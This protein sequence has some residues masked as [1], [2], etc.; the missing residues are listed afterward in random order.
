MNGCAG[1]AHVV[2]KGPHR[3]V[4]RVELPDLCFY[5][6]RNLMTDRW[7][8]IRQLV[9]P[10]KARMEYE[11]ARGVAERGLPTYLP[12]ALGEQRT[13]F[14]PGESILITR[15]LE[16]TQELH[17]FAV[18]CLARLPAARQARLRQC[19][20]LELGRLVARMHDAGI[21]HNDLHP[22]NILVRWGEDDNL[23]LFLVD[24]S[25]VRL[26][27]PLSW[28]QSRQNLVI[29][30]RWFVLRAAAA[31]ATAF[32][33]RIAAIDNRA[34]VAPRCVRAKAWTS[35]TK[36]KRTRSRPT[37]VSGGA[38]IA[39]ASKTIATTAASKL[40]ACA[41]TRSWIWTR[42]CWRCC[43]PTRTRLLANPACASLKDSPSSTVI[44]WDVVSDGQPRT[45]IYKRFLVSSWFHP[46]TTLLRRTPALRSWIQGQGFRERGL[47]TARPLAV[48]HRCRRGLYREGYLLAEKI[49][50]AQDLREFLANLKRRAPECKMAVLRRQIAQVATVLRE[51]HRR[52]LSHRDLKAANV[53]VSRDS[54]TFYSPFSDMAWTTGTPS[55]LPIF[56]TSVWLID[57]VGVRRY[58]WLARARMV[59]NLTRLNASFQQRDTLTRTDRLRFLRTYLRWS[60][61][62]KGDWKSWW[63]AIERATQ[64]KISRNQKRGRP[65]E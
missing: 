4:Y 43:R 35:P 23:D 21:C 37:C 6:K 59:Q 49:E 57:L 28:K 56:A 44:E 54:S 5:V 1:Q 63:R 12:L 53:L 24:L 47:P 40:P 50:N 61:H 33:K 26:G 55:L 42:P 58:R 60:L 3:V 27:R 38:V 64:E 34:K 15:S 2:K 9:R 39:G 36:W 46:W 52:C 45:V 41:G 29:L 62:G 22:A 65:V 31:I 11:R 30:N 13:L 7:C 16:E 48:L 32:G 8:W 17:T 19:M 20:A 14:G 25:A 10:S 51:L 18:N